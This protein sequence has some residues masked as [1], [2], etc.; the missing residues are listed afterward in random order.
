MVS[1]PRSL[2]LLDI[3][4]QQFLY[5]PSFLF[6]TEKIC[7]MPA[8]YFQTALYQECLV[9]VE[10]LFEMDLIKFLDYSPWEDLTILNLGQVMLLRPFQ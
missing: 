9:T 10:V 6:C 3:S 1:F 2:L 5:D 4:T 7:V 8:Y